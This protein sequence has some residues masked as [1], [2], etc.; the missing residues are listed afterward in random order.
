[1]RIHR[2]IL[3]ATLAL[4][5]VVPANAASIDATSLFVDVFA[6]TNNPVDA[7]L[8]MTPGTGVY[9]DDACLTELVFQTSSSPRATILEPPL[10]WKCSR[11]A[12]R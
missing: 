4:A 2:S 1:M 9:V 3:L 6:G 8:R 12:I 5:P 7:G 10:A 11:G